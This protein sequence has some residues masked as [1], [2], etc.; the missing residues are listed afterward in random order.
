MAGLLVP[1]LFILLVVIAILWKK[2]LLVGGSVME[3]GIYIQHERFIVYMKSHLISVHQLTIFSFIF[4]FWS[5]FCDQISNGWICSPAT[6]RLSRSKQQQTIFIHQIKLVKVV[7]AQCTRHKPFFSFWW[8]FYP[9]MFFTANIS[10]AMVVFFAGPTSWWHRSRCETTFFKIK[11]REP[12]IYHRSRHDF[13][14]ATPKP[15]K[16]TWLLRWGKSTT[17]CLWIHGK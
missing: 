12:G 17:A 4:L 11:S 6:S 9:C 14:F 5:L 16:V 3:K 2:G 8:A 10:N 13:W 7:L 15:C 1:V